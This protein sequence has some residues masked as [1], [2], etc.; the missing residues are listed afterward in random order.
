MLLRAKIPYI[1]F[2]T[3]CM[4]DTFKKILSRGVLRVFQILTLLTLLIL[5]LAGKSRNIIPN[6]SSGLILYLFLYIR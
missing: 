3:T 4:P 6:G 1:H 5:A 2:K